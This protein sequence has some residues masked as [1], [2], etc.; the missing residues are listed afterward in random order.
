MI[1]KGARP[2][3]PDEM[4]SIGDPPSDGLWEL[5]TLCWAHDAVDRPVISSVIAYLERQT[6]A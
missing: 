4:I 5:T 1:V 6:Q 3:R 2:E